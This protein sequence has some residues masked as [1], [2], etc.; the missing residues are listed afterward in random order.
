MIYKCRPLT[1]ITFSQQDSKKL[2]WPTKSEHVNYNCSEKILYFYRFY[3][4]FYTI[5]HSKCDTKWIFAWRGGK[6][7]QKEFNPNRLSRPR[8]KTQKFV[9][10]MP[11]CA[12]QVNPMMTSSKVRKQQKDTKFKEKTWHLLFQCKGFSLVAFNC[13]RLRRKTT[14]YSSSWDIYNLSSRFRPYP[15]ASSYSDL[16]GKPGHIQ[17]RDNIAWKWETAV[18]SWSQN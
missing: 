12:N 2:L 9:P 8:S 17:V 10:S 1:I 16:P 18:S 7:K 6:R 4:Y 14:L 3:F 15:G 11:T 5:F 13:H